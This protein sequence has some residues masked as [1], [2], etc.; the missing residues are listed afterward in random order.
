MVLKGSRVL[1]VEDDPF[2]ALDVAA[3]LESEGA[4][5]VG[6]AYDLAAALAEDAGLS[7]AVLD[8]RLEPEDT[9]PVAARLAERGMPFLLQTTDPRAVLDA[10]PDALVLSKPFPAETLVLTLETLL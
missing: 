10:R 6:P 9:L 3:N 1:V 8:L 2:I 7:A 5:V 4:T